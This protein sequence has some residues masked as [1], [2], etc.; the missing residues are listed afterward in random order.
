MPEELSFRDLIRRVR[1]GDGDAAAQLVR[2]FEPAIRRAA[3][4][5][6]HDSRLR[7]FLDSLDICQS[8]LASFFVRAAL[9]QYQLDEPGQLLRLL[10]AMARNKLANLANQH[11]AG[12]RDYR[13]ETAGDSQARQA[14]DPGPSPSAQVAAAELLQQARHRL[15]AEELQLLELRQQGHPWAEIAA[16]LGGRPD[17]LRMRLERAVARVIKELGLEGV[18]HE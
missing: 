2:R 14:R 9:G 1:A 4:I 12:R 6:L 13:R 16:E 15:S 8:V 7:R 10:A 11:Q 18:S 5:R 17:A 3:R